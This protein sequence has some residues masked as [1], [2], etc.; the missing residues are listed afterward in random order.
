MM[1]FVI[2]KDSRILLKL[3]DNYWGTYKLDSTGLD[4]TGGVDIRKMVCNE[5]YSHGILTYSENLQHRGII[6]HEG[7]TFFIYTASEFET[8]SSPPSMGSFWCSKEEINSYKLHGFDKHIL[9]M[10]LDGEKIGM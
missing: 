8:N 1:V 2:D 5:L 7:R 4:S 3:N 10:I 9:T 6:D